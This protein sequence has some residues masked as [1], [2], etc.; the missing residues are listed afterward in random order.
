[1]PYRRQQQQSVVVAENI[2]D[3]VTVTVTAKDRIGWNISYD[4][5]PAM[6]S[7]HRI[8]L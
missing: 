1:M 7:Y 6:V 4:I 8:I 3:K 5:T 2:E